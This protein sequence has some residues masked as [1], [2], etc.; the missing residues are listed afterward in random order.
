MILIKNTT[1]VDLYSLEFC[2]N[3]EPII[4]IHT[5]DAAMKFCLLDVI[6][7]D[8]IVSFQCR[9]IINIIFLRNALRRGDVLSI[10]R[11]SINRS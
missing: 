7:I 9:L 1:M 2:K 6:K 10:I 8:R 3:I 11:Y 4:S 5:I